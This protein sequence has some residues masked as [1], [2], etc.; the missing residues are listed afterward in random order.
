MKILI[1]F[2]FTE[3]QFPQYVSTGKPYDYD[4]STSDFFNQ[5]VS[6]GYSFII[7]HKKQA[8]STDDSENPDVVVVY[9][10]VQIAFGV[11][12]LLVCVVFILFKRKS[13]DDYRQIKLHRSQV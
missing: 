3:K 9:V 4:T 11:V 7:G 6:S 12:L 5:N 10:V 13:V 2:S 1:L 8:E